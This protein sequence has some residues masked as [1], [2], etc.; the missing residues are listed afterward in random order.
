V[1]TE[2]CGHEPPLCVLCAFF[3]ELVR[4]YVSVVVD[5]D[6]DDAVALEPRPGLGL[7]FG[8]HDSLY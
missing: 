3:K 1:W 7:P 6:D 8:F 2:K 5:D 4:S